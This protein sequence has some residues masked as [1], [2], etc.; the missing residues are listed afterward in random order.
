[1]AG[2]T[3]P[4]LKVFEATMNE[5]TAEGLTINVE[6]WNLQLHIKKSPTGLTTVLKYPGQKDQI[7]SVESEN[8]EAIATA[9]FK[10]LEAFSLRLWTPEKFS[11]NVFDQFKSF[12]TINKFEVNM[13]AL[14]KDDSTPTLK[15]ILTKDKTLDQKFIQIYRWKNGIFYRV[16]TNFGYNKKKTYLFPNEAIVFGNVKEYLDTLYY[17]LKKRLAYISEQSTRQLSAD[18]FLREKFAELI[19]KEKMY[20][21]VDRLNASIGLIDNFDQIKFF[22]QLDGKGLT[23]YPDASPVSYDNITFTTEVAQAIDTLKRHTDEY[24]EKVWQPTNMA[25]LLNSIAEYFKDD[26]EFQVKRSSGVNS[27]DGRTLHVV[28]VVYNNKQYTFGR[29]YGSLRLECEVLDGERKELTGE[30]KLSSDIEKSMRHASIWA[31]KKVKPPTGKRNRDD[32]DTEDDSSRSRS[33]RGED[34]DWGSEAGSI[35]SKSDLLEDQ[36]SSLAGFD[37]KEDETEVPT[38]PTGLEGGTGGLQSEFLSIE[39]VLSRLRLSI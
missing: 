8:M 39:D 28:Q 26:K 20:V 7:M 23:Y 11:R 35:V 1:M 27:T 33:R 16:V 13:E 21:R 24:V 10:T 4:Y 29:A 15:L 34:S 3:T 25:R 17:D 6:E 12:A 14:S 18:G 32:T 38:S 37:W 31:F 22:L 9:V 36:T 5:P 30:Y 2:V 19:Q